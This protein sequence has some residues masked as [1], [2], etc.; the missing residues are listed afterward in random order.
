MGGLGGVLAL[1]ALVLGWELLLPWA[2]GVL[3][4]EYAISLFVAGGGR[5]DAAPLVGAGLVLLGELVSWSL[6]LRTRMR[7]ERPVFLLHVWTLV[8]AVVASLAAGAMLV[9]LAASDVGGGLAWTGIGTA[10]A[11]GAVLLVTRASSS[12]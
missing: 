8:L 3:G 2:L 1:A 6:A 7:T 10:A 11:V 5:A 12:A 9:A 4:A